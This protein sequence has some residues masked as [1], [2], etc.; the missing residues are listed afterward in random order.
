MVMVSMRMAR[1]M[2]TSLHSVQGGAYDTL[3]MC[4]FG[5][6]DKVWNMHAWLVACNLELYWVDY[7]VGNEIMWG[8]GMR[9][10]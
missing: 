9:M 8:C 5:R 7:H 3:C 10:D 6:N 4:T 1:F 2:K